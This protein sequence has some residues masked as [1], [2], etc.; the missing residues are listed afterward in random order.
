MKS[1]I[2]GKEMT[3][4]KEN[5]TL[6]FRKENFDVLFHY[7]LCEDTKEQFTTTELDDKNINQLYNKY[8]EKF[9]LPFPDDIKTLR[10]KYGLSAAKMADVLGFGANVYRNYE[11]GEIPSESNARLIQLAQDAEEFRKLIK[12]SGVYKGGDL[13]KVLSR[14]DEIIEQ[15]KDIFSVK[16]EEYL[17]GEN[18]ADIY[19]GYRKP[20]LDRFTEMIVYFTGKLEPFKTKMNKLL[21][22]ADFLHFSKTCF[23]ISGARYRAIDMGPVPNNFN[24]LFEYVSNN[25][26]IDIWQTEFPE[27][28]LG[29]QFKPNPKRKFNPEVFSGEEINVLDQVAKR[30][31]RTKGPDIVKISHEE[32][33]WI[34]NFHDGKKLIPYD[35]GFELTTI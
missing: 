31:E 10:E 17:M 35:C 24:S 23:S 34:D 5:R 7:Y 9:H 32:K 14:I 16:F 13:V 2:T 22:Y 30:F 12:L 11:N 1:P 4:Q 6:S 20:S 18:T 27:G 28:K 21:F 26:Y 3:L 33:A 15:E 19:S 8:R 29:E 25:D